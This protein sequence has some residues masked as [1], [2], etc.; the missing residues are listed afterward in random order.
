M[1]RLKVQWI[2][3]DYIKDYRV[4]RL[5]QNGHKASYCLKISHESFSVPNTVPVDIL[6]LNEEVNDYGEVMKDFN[7][8]PQIS[9]SFLML[10]YPSERLNYLHEILSFIWSHLIIITTPWSI[11]YNFHFIDVKT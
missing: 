4:C 11:S 2:V 5:S 8:I 1:V 9:V 6:Y 7:T 10:L 3:I